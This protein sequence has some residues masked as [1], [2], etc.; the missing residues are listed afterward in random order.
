MLVIIDNTEKIKSGRVP[1][2][3]PEA[4]SENKYEIVVSETIEKNIP[5]NP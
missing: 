1:I 5:I 4:H 2:E 3:F